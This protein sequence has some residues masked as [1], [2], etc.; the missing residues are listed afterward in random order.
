MTP[1]VLKSSIVQIVKLHFGVLNVFTFLL[2]YLLNKRMPGSNKYIHMYTKS[3]IKTSKLKERRKKETL[4]DSIPHLLS[5]KDC[6]L[7][8]RLSRNCI[9]FSFLKVNVPQSKAHI[10]RRFPKIGRKVIE[11]SYVSGQCRQTMQCNIHSSAASTGNL[12]YELQ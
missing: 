3:R 9:I 7:T 8:I 11:Y 12:L 4:W 10:L 6:L 2:V 1:K 5:A